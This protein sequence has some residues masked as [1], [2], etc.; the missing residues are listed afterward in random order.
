[1]YVSLKVYSS[2]S[3]TQDP[4]S[5]E[6]KNQPVSHDQTPTTG[7]TQITVTGPEESESQSSSTLMLSPP[8]SVSYI[9]STT[10]KE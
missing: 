4:G 10:F 1:M 2:K 5:A 3:G 8:P 7:V 6:D 9:Y